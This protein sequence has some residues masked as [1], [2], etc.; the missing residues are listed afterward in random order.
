M[1]FNGRHP[2]T[3]REA[4]TLLSKAK[5]WEGLIFQKKNPKLKSEVELMLLAPNI[6][7]GAE[8][9][10]F[11]LNFFGFGI[12]D[13]TTKKSAPNVRVR[14]GARDFS[15]IFSYMQGYHYVL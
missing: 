9:G 8:A 14:T 11:S 13:S 12:I 15:S 7:D 1:P 2:L 3:I 10:G 6:L 4:I 5:L